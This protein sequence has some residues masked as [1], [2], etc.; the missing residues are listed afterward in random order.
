MI[1]IADSFWYPTDSNPF[2]IDGTYGHNWSAFIYDHEI[3]Y[4]TNIYLGAKL[5]VL[6][7]CPDVDKEFLR[8]FDFLTYEL[9]YERNV[10]LKVCQGMDAVSVMTQFNSV[11]HAITYG[12]S[13]EKYMVHSTTLSAWELIKKDGELVVNSRNLGYVCTGPNVIYTPG[14]RLYFDI[15]KMYK[16]GIVTRDGLHLVKVKDR[17]PLKEYLLEAITADDV[18]TQIQ[19]T[20]TLFTKRANEVFYLS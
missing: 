8:L 10:I 1:Y 5:Y 15:R 6:R 16:D 17:L 9:S 12:S 13:D 11:P 18:P 14:V 2:T 7:V 3:S 4:F 20:P 19:W